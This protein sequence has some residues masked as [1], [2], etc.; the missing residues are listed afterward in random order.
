[1][2][3]IRVGVRVSVRVR[4]NVRG[5][6]SV[7]PGLGNQLESFPSISLLCV[8]VEFA[9]S[10]VRPENKR[11]MK[12]SDSH[13]QS[14]LLRVALVD[15]VNDGLENIIPPLLVPEDGLRL[16]P[17]PL[18]ITPHSVPLLPFFPNFI[19]NF[20]DFPVQRS[21]KSFINKVSEISMK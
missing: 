5:S 9:V 17:V 12:F 19:L 21:L 6:V 11:G 15:L 7:D 13:C 16:R 4:V 2:I 18:V 1:M 10:L 20:S 8:L 3:R 14:N